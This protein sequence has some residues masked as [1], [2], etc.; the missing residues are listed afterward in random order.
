[1]VGGGGTS[2]GAAP[3]S[4]VNS[5]V[6]SAAVEVGGFGGFGLVGWWGVGC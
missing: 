6:G 5:D 2:E 3:A 4:F 1:M